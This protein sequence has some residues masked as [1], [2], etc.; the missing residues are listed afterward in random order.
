MSK[1]SSAATNVQIATICS[2]RGET[3]KLQPN[4]CC[5]PTER[6]Q[7][8]HSFTCGI[9]LFFHKIWL[10]SVKKSQKSIVGLTLVLVG[11]SSRHKRNTTTLTVES[12]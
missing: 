9:I 4:C 12:C 10:Q 11:S 7:K 2:T 8:V 3:E 6:Y 5:R 1:F